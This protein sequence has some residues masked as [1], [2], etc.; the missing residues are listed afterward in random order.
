MMTKRSS[1]RIRQF[2]VASETN[3]WSEEE[4]ATILVVAVRGRA[5]DMLR[6]M[7]ATDKDDYS[8]LFAALEI[9]FVERRTVPT[10]AV[11][12]TTEYEHVKSRPKKRRF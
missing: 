8:K 2:K 6:S 4:K 7:P 9:H 5:L 12:S 11:S 3:K 10:A 1:K